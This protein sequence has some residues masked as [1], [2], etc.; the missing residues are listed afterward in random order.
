MELMKD[1]KFLIFAISL[2]LLLGIITLVEIASFRTF[3][4]FF[5]LVKNYTSWFI[6]ITFGFVFFNTLNFFWRKT[7]TKILHQKPPEQFFIFLMILTVNIFIISLARGTALYLFETFFELF[8]VLFVQWV[9]LVYISFKLV[10]KYEISLKY[11]IAAELNI[12]I[13]AFLIISFAA[14]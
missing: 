5:L 13:Y 4:E 6:G 3:S 11:L 10:N 7:E 12:I 9:A 2:F 1:K 14:R 8:H